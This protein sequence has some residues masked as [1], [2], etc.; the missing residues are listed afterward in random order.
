MLKRLALLGA[1]VMALPFTAFAGSQVDF[2]NAGGTLTGSSSGMSLTGATLIGVNGLNGGSLVAGVNLGSF[3]FNT[4]ALTSGSL[5]MGGTFAG[6]GA[7]TIIGN[8]INGVT[9]GTIFSGT[10][11]GPVTWSVITLA[12]GTHNYTLV[13]AISGHWANGVSASGATVQLSY[14]TG[15]GWFN[16]RVSGS[17]GDTNIGSTLAPEPGT[18]LLLGTGL[19]G[20]AGAVR[21]RLTS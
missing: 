2:T 18:L 5:Q 6:G 10:F 15:K 9:A 13:G 4:G 20:I 16:G 8:G 3:S 17:S 11:S 14:N 21:K 12:N 19:L 7:V 1:L